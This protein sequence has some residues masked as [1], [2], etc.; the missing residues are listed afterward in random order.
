MC[1]AKNQ[2]ILGTGPVVTCPAT[3]QM[4]LGTGPVVTC[5]ATNQRILGTGPPVTCPARVQ[6]MSWILIINL[7]S[8]RNHFYTLILHIVL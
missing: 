2:L 3:N 6:M 1:T 5:P 7:I 8:T 4:I